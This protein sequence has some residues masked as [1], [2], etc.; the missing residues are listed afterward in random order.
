MRSIGIVC[1]GDTV[2]IDVNLVGT[3]GDVFGANRF[4]C[5]F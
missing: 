5:T 4:L 1:N 3:R 2:G